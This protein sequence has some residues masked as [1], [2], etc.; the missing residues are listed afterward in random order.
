MT[1]HLTFKYS[2]LEASSLIRGVRYAL[3]R[4]QGTDAVGDGLLVLNSGPAELPGFVAQSSLR[5][6]HTRAL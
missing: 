4:L 5:S 3:Q 1:V 6:V 2:G